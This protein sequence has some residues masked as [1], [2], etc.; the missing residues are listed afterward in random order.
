MTSPFMG[1]EAFTGI[2]A[3]KLPFEL[4]W[5]RNG[6]TI[7]GESLLILGPKSVDNKSWILPGAALLKIFAALP[8]AE[9]RGPGQGKDVEIEIPGDRSSLIGSAMNRS[10]R[11]Q[12]HD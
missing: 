3:R 4:G 11:N 9:I 5:E 12:D 6:R 2:E 1:I 8:G 7:L 10:G